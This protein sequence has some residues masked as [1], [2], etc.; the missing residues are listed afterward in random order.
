MK[1]IIILIAIAI[2]G[3]GLG[4]G[5]LNAPPINVVAQ[6]VGIG[7]DTLKA[8][9]TDAN[10]AFHITAVLGNQ[11]FFKNQYDACIVKSPQ[12]IHT[13]STVFCKLTDMSSKVVA[14]GHKVLQAKLAA[15]TPTNIPIQTKISTGSL[16]VSNIADVTIV[17][18]GP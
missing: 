4:V 7:H 12:V 14:E 3:A 17:V 8:P 10:V 9:I 16:L 11:G 2:A 5:F 15:N 1:P 6:D 13:G 18:Q